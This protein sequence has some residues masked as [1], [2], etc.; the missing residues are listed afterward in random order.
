MTSMG[1]LMAYS[2]VCLCVIVL[3]YRMVSIYL[4]MDHDLDT[5]IEVESVDLDASDVTASIKFSLETDDETESQN[6]DEKSV[7]TSSKMDGNMQGDSANLE[8]KITSEKIGSN[9][10]LMTLFKSHVLPFEHKLVFQCRIKRQ[11]AFRCIASSLFY[12]C[13]KLLKSLLSHI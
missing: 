3:R 12:H 4:P 13:I 2:S 8:A 6:V 11:W 5:R 10:K 1:T 9:G 7:A